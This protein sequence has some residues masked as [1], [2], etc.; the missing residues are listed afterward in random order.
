MC[1]NKFNL[2]DKPIYKVLNYFTGDGSRDPEKLP[3]ISGFLVSLDPGL[4]TVDSMI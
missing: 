1:I 3:P 2:H 4:F